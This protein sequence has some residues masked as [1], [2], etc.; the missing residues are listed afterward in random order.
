MAKDYNELVAYAKAHASDPLDVAK[1]LTAWEWTSLGPGP[2]DGITVPSDVVLLLQSAC[3]WRDYL[4]R[5]VM[6][7]IGI[8]GRR[9]GFYDVPFQVSHATSELKINGKWIWF[10]ATFGNFFVSKTTGKLLSYAEARAS[11]PDVIIK[12]SNLEGWQHKFIDPDTIDPDSAFSTYKDTLLYHPFSYR[13]R[14]DSVGAEIYSLYFPEKATYD[15]PPVAVE[16]IGD[17]WN[18][19]KDVGDKYSWIRYWDTRDANG[20]LDVRHVYNDDGTVDFIDWDQRDQYS[21]SKRTTTISASV[22]FD[23]RDIVYDDGRRQIYDLDQANVAT[24]STKN[25]FYA[26]SKVLDYQIGTYDD[27]RSW[28]VDYDNGNRYT[29]SSYKDVF[30]VN[31]RLIVRS[32]NQDNGTITI[33]DWSAIPTIDGTSGNNYLEGTSATDY[34]RGFGGND[35]LVGQGGLDRMEGGAGNDVYYIDQLL[36]D[37]S[38][39]TGGGTDTVYASTSYILPAEVERLVLLDGTFDG[40]GNDTANTIVGNAGANVLSGLGGDDLLIGGAGNDLLAGGVG[41][42]RLEGGLGTDRM[43]G[44]AGAD[45]FLWRNIADAGA[46]TSTADVVKDFNI[47]SGDRLHLGLIDA[48][49]Q[50]SGNQSFDFIGTDRFSEA[51]QIRYWQKSSETVLFLNTDADS[52]YEGLIRIAGH[53]TPTA[54][55]FIV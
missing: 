35:T 48:D 32:Y 28:F 36:D 34:L 52:N 39:K 53:H 51:G 22:L 9:V 12:H 1:A 41:S 46:T 47:S 5:S 25:T 16:S 44:N 42:D 17:R 23:M 14:A 45:T 24:W 55:W 54:D 33:I 8:E 38:E 37:V 15:E 29:Y 4:L 3:G 6:N 43:Y 31:D 49:S 27:G 2:D 19:R 7:E 18:Q 40:T 30:D 20:D 10:D 21:W 11:W 26:P 13:N 50:H